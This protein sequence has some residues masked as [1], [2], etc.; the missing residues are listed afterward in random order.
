MILPL[1]V[2]NSF[3]FKHC[4]KSFPSFFGQ[5]KS[6]MSSGP[7]KIAVCQFTATND[8]KKNLGLVKSV[9]SNAVKEDAKV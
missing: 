5:K 7:C 9:V 3:R 1:S 8:K 6:R 2:L 4:K